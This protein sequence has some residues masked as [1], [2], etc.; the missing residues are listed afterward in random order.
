MNNKSCSNCE[1]CR[2]ERRTIDEHRDRNIRVCD[3]DGKAVEDGESA[4]KN[5]L[6]YE[7]AEAKK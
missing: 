2:Y 1:Y 6:Y 7:P 3:L 4:A 5:C